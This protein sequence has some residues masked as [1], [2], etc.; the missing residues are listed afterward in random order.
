MCASGLIVGQLARAPDFCMNDIVQF[1]LKHGYPILFAALFARQIGLP[2]PAPLF[3]LAAGALAAAGKI[4]FYEYHRWASDPGQV[5]TTAMIDSLRSAGI[6]STVEIY[7]GQEHAPHLLQGRLERLD[8]VDY[9]HGVQV[10]VRL[11]AQL[12]DT[13]T[14]TA[15]W[16]GD[17]TKNVLVEQRQVRSVVQAMGQATQDGVEQLVQDLRNQPFATTVAA[18]KSAI[19]AAADKQ[20]RRV[21]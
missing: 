18:D 17:T 19:S 20:D 21:K 10:E 9:K 11:F 1:V 5:V 3:L 14:G 4:G 15:V 13:K 12:L 2:V 6:F 8:E 16:A 7:D